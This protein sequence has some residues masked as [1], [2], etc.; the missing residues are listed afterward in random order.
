MSYWRE[1]EDL[2]RE[3]DERDAAASDRKYVVYVLDTDYGHYVGH[4]GNLRARIRAHQKGEV[5]STAGGHPK[6]VWTS[7]KFSTRADAASFEAALKNLRDQ[8]SPRFRELIGLNPIPYWRRE[9]A[10]SFGR[11]AMVV[12]KALGKVLITLIVRALGLGRR[13]RKPHHRRRRR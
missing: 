5:P 9:K 6:R 7:R 11:V 1:P 4:T 12:G 3:Q 2:G 10:A 13:R 8:R